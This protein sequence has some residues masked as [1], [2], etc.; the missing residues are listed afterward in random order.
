M[1]QLIPSIPT[2]QLDQVQKY[3]TVTPPSPPHSPTRQYSRSASVTATIS[4]F[5]QRVTNPPPPQPAPPSSPIKHPPR[6]HHP[7]QPTPLSSPARHAPRARRATRTDAQLRHGWNKTGPRFPHVAAR[8]R[9]A[10][11][12]TLFAIVP[13]FREYCT[14]VTDG[15]MRRQGCEGF[16]RM[17]GGRAGNWMC[18]CSAEGGGVA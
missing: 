17:G 11:A 10:L 16:P 1:I 18:G 3:V 15:R 4:S 14:A 8:S 9:R 12:L 5:R 7:L 13:C 6:A 2:S